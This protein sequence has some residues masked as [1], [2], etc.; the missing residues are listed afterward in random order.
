[1]SDEE[2]PIAQQIFGSDVDTFVKAA[3]IVEEVMHPDIID[4]NM[5]C[6]LY[7]SYVERLGYDNSAT[8]ILIPSEKKYGVVYFEPNW[9]LDY[10]WIFCIMEI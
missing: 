7:T 6:L 3:K 5:G 1:M 2:R 10:F 9:K 8:L 4:I